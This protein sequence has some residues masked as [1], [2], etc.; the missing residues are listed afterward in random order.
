LR[1]EVEQFGIDVVVIEP[2]GIKS[3]W[4][5]IAADNLYK[6]SGNTNY[7]SLVDSFAVIMRKTEAKNADPIVIV[8]LV[9]K[10]IGAK[11]PKTRYSGGYMAKL[12]LFMRWLLPDRLFDK[13]LMSQLK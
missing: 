9:R 12:G 11:K 8:D 1:N 5:G 10:A 2:G 6:V 4:S 13:M 3:E 7:K